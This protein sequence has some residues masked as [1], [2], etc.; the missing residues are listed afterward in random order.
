MA[1]KMTFESDFNLR[2][3]FDTETILAGF[4]KIRQEMGSLTSKQN[5][6]SGVDKDLKKLEG[7]FEDLKVKSQFLDSPK[8]IKNYNKALN[9]LQQQ[10]I[11][12]DN[13]FEAISRNTRGT[14]SFSNQEIQEN[15]K[16]LLRLEALQQTYNKQLRQQQS[17]LKERLKDIGYSKVE[18]D[19]IAETV[20]NQK[21][22]NK[23]LDERL[24]KLSGKRTAYLLSSWGTPTDTEN[25]QLRRTTAQNYIKKLGS[26]IKTFVT[27]D[28]SKYDVEL[29]D[30]NQGSLILGKGNKSDTGKKAVDIVKNAIINEL[31]SEIKRARTDERGIEQIWTAITQRIANSGFSKTIDFTNADQL[32][33]NIE[34]RLQAARDIKYGNTIQMQ[35]WDEKHSNFFNF[36]TGNYSPGVQQISESYVDIQRIKDSSAAIRTQIEDIKTENEYLKQQSQLKLQSFAGPIQEQTVKMRE[37]VAAEQKEAMTKAEQIARQSEF[38]RQLSSITSWI[39]YSFSLISIWHKFQQVVR[40][41]FNDV[42][43]IDKAFS[44]IALVTNK[45]LSELWNT[46]NQYNAIAD[47]LGQTTEGAIQSSALYYQQG[48]DTVEALKLT[49]DTMKLATLAN[50]DFETSTKQMTAALRG[51]HMEMTEG[52]RVTD[53]YSELA[54]N[55]AADVNGIAYAMSKTSSI[56]ASAGMSFENTAAFITN[57]IE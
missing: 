7:L 10:I 55:A 13:G 20:A 2:G 49:E 34:Q 44:S 23:V 54:A 40:Q 37:L 1:K 38:N 17:L 3:N 42:S 28:Q 48:L 12:V 25:Q 4:K 56:A 47:K 27:P 46:Y 31:L 57:M 18:A 14:F 5:I 41:T 9:A 26:S 33:A 21:E 22:L 43:R 30:L 50:A 45:S 51:F 24:S 11:K 16:R 36:R 8:G 35:T 6:F 53:V 52:S 39:Q 32:K 29:K 19:T 15:E